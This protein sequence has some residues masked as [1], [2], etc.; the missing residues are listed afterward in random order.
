MFTAE[1]QSGGYEMKKIV[2]GSDKAGFNL[3][4]SI[5][6]YLLAND[7][8]VLDVGTQDPENPV[9]YY[10]TASRVAKKIQSGEYEKGV[11]FCGTGMGMSI[12]ANKYSGVFAACCESVYSAEKA[13]ANNDANILCMGGN[14]LGADNAA[15]MLDIFMSTEFG[16]GFTKERAEY[17][18]GL[19]EKVVEL[20]EALRK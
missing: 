14:I 5:K 8:D 16:G 9:F 20:D 1:E 13:R 12:V 10:E 6:A 18:A 7:Y 2:I 17:L 3:K 11:L 15:N 19:K 4:E